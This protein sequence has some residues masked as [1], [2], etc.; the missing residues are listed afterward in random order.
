MLVKACARVSRIGPE[1]L[2]TLHEMNAAHIDSE[3]SSFDRVFAVYVASVVP[4]LA[5]FVVEMQR[6]CIPGG[7]ILV[8]NHFATNSGLFGWIEDAAIP[9]AGLIGF[10]P[11]FYYSDLLHL[12]R[13]GLG[14]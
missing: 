11:D 3:D 1:N 4:N 14:S 6:V 5:S 10:K 2:E 8:F 13:H 12:S 7:D 9:F